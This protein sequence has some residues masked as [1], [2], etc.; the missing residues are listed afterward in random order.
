MRRM[1]YA[2]VIILLVGLLVAAYF[3]TR[4]STPTTPQG[5]ET[6]EGATTPET[7]NTN[8]GDDNTSPTPRNDSTSS[9][10]RVARTVTMQNNTFE[11]DMLSVPAGTTVTWTN[12]DAAEHTVTEVAAPT[13]GAGPDSGRL[14]EGQSY[15]LNFVTPGTYTYRCTLHPEMTGTI[16]VTEQQ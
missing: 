3:A 2:V 15:S 11:P 6:P 7:G 13:G 16:T 8:T 1:I 12:R 14:R 10:E 4:S 5:T 9:S